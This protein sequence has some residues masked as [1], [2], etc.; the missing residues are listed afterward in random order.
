[1]SEIVLVQPPVCQPP[2][3]PV[4]SVPAV[5][6]RLAVV[7][8]VAEASTPVH[9]PTSEADRVPLRTGAG[10]LSRVSANTR[11]RQV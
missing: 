2:P 3:V 11:Y 6:V 4:I 1:L 8:V 5:V 10:S 9:D 7:A